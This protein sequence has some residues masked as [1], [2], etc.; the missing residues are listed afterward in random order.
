MASAWV[1]TDSSTP[2]TYHEGL[3]LDGWEL[4]EGEI[5]LRLTTS[6]I[7]GSDMHTSTGKRTDPAAPLV[8]G[9]EGVGS[10]LA[11]KRPG[12][13]P[14]DV[15]TWCLAT[16]QCLLSP[17]GGGGDAT[18]PCCTPCATFHLPQKCS[19]VLKYGH[20]PW[21]R[22]T[23]PSPREVAEGLS[24]CF[25]SH[26]L[27]RAGTP[28]VSL[29]RAV[30]LGLPEG[31]L[32]SVNCA[33]ATAIASWRA[34][35]RHLAA[36]TRDTLAVVT[37][38]P[39]SSTA[40]TTS[41][42][43]IFGA[44]LLGLY[45]CAAAARESEFV[46]VVDT[47]PSR[48]E[49]AKAFGAHATVLTPPGMGVEAVVGGILGACSGSGSVGGGLVQAR[50]G[51]DAVIEVCGVPDVVA[52]GLRLV[53]VGGV[54]V[55]VGMVHP[56]S[57]LGGITGEGVIRKSC[58]L[59]GVHN[60]EARDLEEAVEL[61]CQLQCGPRAVE[62]GLWER[63]FSPPLPLAHLPQALLLAGKGEWSRVVVKP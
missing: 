7:C 56:A 33:G 59:V 13:I 45:A 9:H 6:T 44:G 60:Y 30:G 37:Q 17:S 51:F 54:I 1:F 34:A 57:A 4:R 16:P 19:R 23:A 28:I 8:L 38:P 22:T 49:L 12:V 58:A 35:Q 50:G 63:L 3:S 55:L 41:T 27:L 2:Q 32:A 11:S 24:G 10:V 47:S 25:A 53:R 15:L 29:G 40:S 48:L 62:G 20:A 52:S 61:L 36:S 26:V 14:G 5:F 42:V 18:P 46:C 39:S 43:L 21:P 31:A